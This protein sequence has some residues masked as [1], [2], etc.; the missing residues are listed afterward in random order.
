M[1]TGLTTG[2]FTVVGV[3]LNGRSNLGTQRQ[4]QDAAADLHYE[5]LREE[6]W[7]FLYAGRLE[8][9]G[10]FMDLAT[11]LGAELEDGDLSK[12]ESSLM[13]LR[14]MTFRIGIVCGGDGESLPQSAR[15]VRATLNQI[16]GRM[17]ADKEVAAYW[18]P[19]RDAVQ[20]FAQLANADLT[21]APQHV[22]AGLND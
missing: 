14:S 16:K 11:E 5:A 22:I 13:S 10:R 9:Y 4:M 3:W 21:D 15:L 17:E 1:I 2:L 12:A 18:A 19:F 20:E 8:L 7:K 6:R